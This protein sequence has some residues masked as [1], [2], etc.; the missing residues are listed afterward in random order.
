MNKRA[1]FLMI[2]AGLAVSA[3]ERH[4]PSED[5]DGAGLSVKGA[6]EGPR[7][8]G[9]S[10]TD[11]PVT[12][13]LYVDQAAV[14]DLY[15][16]EASNI[17]LKRSKNPKVREFAQMMIDHHSKTLSDLQKFVAD[18]PVN[19]AV[20][21]NVDPRRR[22]MLTNLEKAGDTEFDEQYLGQQAHAHDEAYNLHRSFA[23]GG[24]YPELGVIAGQVAELVQQHQKTLASLRSDTSNSSK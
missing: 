1:A 11:D 17:A 22:A 23:N 20:P 3:C 13:T 4:D 19:R 15:E 2:A 12:T 8:E 5:V 18:N 16:I 24:D 7:P 14:G 10:S 6:Y 21:Q 9:V